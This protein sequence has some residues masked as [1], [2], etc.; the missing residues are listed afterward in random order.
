MLTHRGIEANLEKCRDITEMRSPENLKEIH[1]LI[2]RMMARF[3]PK[4]AEKIK[5]IIQLLRK[6]AKFNWTPECEK[7]FFT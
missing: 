3:V 6:T 4:L 2:N 7:Y 5:Y 1:K